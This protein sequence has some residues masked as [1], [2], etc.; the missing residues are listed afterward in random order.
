MRLAPLLLALS[1]PALCQPLTLHYT[2]PTQD[3]Q[4]QAL[5]IGNG[6]LGAMIFGGAPQE[7]LQLNEISLWT[8][9]EKDTGRYQN[10]ADL[11]LDLDHGAPSGYR[12]ALDISTAIHTIS[13]TADEIAYTR[14]YFASAPNQVLVFRFTADHPGAYSGTLRLADAHHAAVAAAGN[15][16]TA[17]GKLDNGLQYET[18]V[19]VLNTGGSLIPGDGTLRISRADSLTILVDAGTNYLQDRAHAW[20]GDDPHARVSAQL[21]EAAARSFDDLRGAHLNDYQRLFRRVSLDLGGD[22]GANKVPTDERLAAY[23]KGATDPALEALFFQFGRYLLISSSRPGS[24]PANLQGLWNNSN[25]PPW[26]SDY[27]SNINIEMNYWPAE[28]ANL[29]EC[30]IPFFDYVDSL[31]GVRTEATRAHYP[32]V[33]GWTVQ[34]ENNIFGAGS[35]KW[36][37]PGSAWYAQQFWE[38]YAFTRD[39]EF[40]RKTAYPVLKEVAEFWQ[41]HLVA[42]PDGALVT[43]DGWSPEHGPEEPGVTYDQELVYDL[44]TNYIE[45]AKTLDIDPEFRTAVSRLRD[46]L[47]KPKIG[48]W[49]QLMEWP[50]DRDDI[51]DEHRHVS[52]LFALHPGTADFAGDHAGAGQRGPDFPARARRPFHRLGDGLAHQLLGAPARRRPCASPAAQPAAPGGQGGGH[53]LRQGRR[54]LLQPVR[55]PPAVPDRRQLRRHRRHRRD[56]AAIANGRDSS[57]ARAARGV[58]RRLRTGTPGTRQLHRGHDLEERRAGIGD[59]ALAGRRQGHGTI[60]KPEPSGDAGGQPPNRRPFPVSRY[61]PYMS[62]TYDS[63]VIGTGQ[64]GP[65]LAVRLAKAGRNVAVI[66]RHLVGGTCVNTGCIPTKTLVASARVAYMARRAA[67]YGVVIGGAVGMD[68]AAAK[69]RKDRVSGESRTGLESWLGSTPGC[70]LIRGHA[71]FTVRP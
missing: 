31:R 10:L 51:R 15:L 48:A 63:I 7:H 46:Q 44:F 54:R 8:G 59:G 4:S 39:Q 6:R 35:F 30:A 1:G 40:L 34:T 18:R 49:G 55:H 66:E 70:T 69:A 52:H 60:W 47:L 43:P 19:L 28:V 57:A 3:W 45:A 61:H 25:N 16:L 2:H 71:R 67:E 42:R 29:S 26:R 5:P 62:P 24:L 21:R 68:M 64:S 23:G 58:A 9:D 37:P 50:E 13:Y 41:D 12:R 20:R 22:P 11:F 36:N 14:E 65:S 33:R 27:H 56:A 32:G 53:R 17:A 38:H